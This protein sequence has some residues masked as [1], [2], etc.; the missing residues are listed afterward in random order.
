MK[1]KGRETLIKL[2]DQSSILL[3]I[4]ESKSFFELSQSHIGKS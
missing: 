1:L 3:G 4:D 2:D